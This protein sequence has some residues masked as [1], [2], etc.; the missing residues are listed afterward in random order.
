MNLNRRAFLQTAATVSAATLA[1]PMILPARAASPGTVRWLMAENTT[2][3]WD[4]AANTTLANINCEY[5]A[6]D[7]LLLYPMAPGTDPIA[8]VPSL[9]TS[10]SVV[11]PY[12]AEFKIRQGVKFHDGADLTAEDIKATLEHFSKPGIARGFYPGALDV[13]IK[14][15]QT[16]VVSMKALG[17]PIS[18]FVF[19]Q[20]YNPILRAK[21]IA[22]GKALQAKMNGTGPYRFVGQEKDEAVFEA[23]EQYWGPNKPSIKR[24]TVRHVSDGNARILALLSGEAE[25]IERLDP[26]QYLSLKQKS[27]IA[28]SKLQSVENRYLHFRNG[29]KPFDD[30][31]VRR[32][33][34]AAID[35][36]AILGVA[37]DAGYAADCVLPPVKLGYMSMPDYG[38]FDPAECQKLLAEAG[39]PNGKGL[40]DL[41]Y[42]TS[43]GF[44]PKSKE[45]CEAITA[46]L[47]A[48]GFPVT[49]TVLEVAAWN[50]RYY[51]PKAG[52][53]IDGG[54]AAGTPEPNMQ[55]LLQY[56]SKIGLITGA[57]DPILDAAIEK[58]MSGTT[59]ELRKEALQKVTLPAIAERMPNLVLY[60]SNMLH[61]MTARLTGVHI[62][63]TAQM[64]F[65][66]AVL[67]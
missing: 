36:E 61:A 46:M 47:Q 4:P 35:R 21:D 37:G 15:A 33:A 11:D 19:L 43:T 34:A 18:S 23:N 8:P 42:I 45:V 63:P 30:W 40:P 5:L 51:N 28:T 14:D 57:N 49:L 50:E 24:V 22:D 54:W 66:K 17:S 9:A 12:T 7:Y 60:N 10:Y 25:L 31:R 13:T 2:G 29:H 27:G 44:Y 58:E 20:A 1:S 48:Q 55:V 52:H 41:E 67:A 62:L 26:E 65:N 39:Y 3:N 59:L 6:F 64:D 38:K 32:A 56:Y 53:M 16:V